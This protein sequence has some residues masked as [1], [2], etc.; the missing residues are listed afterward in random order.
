MDSNSPRR[1]S[2]AFE[3][4]LYAAILTETA[5][6]ALIYKVMFRSP[7]LVRMRVFFA[8][9]YFAFLG[10]AIQQLNKLHR[11]RKE[12]LSDPTPAP[13]REVNEPASRGIA[14]EDTR[15]AL[16]LTGQQLVIIV[17]VFAA[18]IATFSWALRLLD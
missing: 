5:L 14:A 12:R 16:G 7:E 10:W 9:F 15:P 11:N 17:V 6:A 8:I 3:Y 13:D 18:A 2:T 4:F 1:T